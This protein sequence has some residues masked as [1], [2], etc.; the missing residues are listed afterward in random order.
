MA[1]VAEVLDVPPG[2]VKSRTFYALRA[3]REALAGRELKIREP[4]DG[5]RPSP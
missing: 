5:T 2:T 4:P 3:L 1:E